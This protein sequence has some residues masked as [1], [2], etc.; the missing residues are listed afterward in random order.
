[1]PFGHFPNLSEA[2][3][4]VSMSASLQMAECWHQ[5]SMAARFFQQQGA[6]FHRD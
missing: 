2:A 5:I 1:M 6:S 3:A 4:A